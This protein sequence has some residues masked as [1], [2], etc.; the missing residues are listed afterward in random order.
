MHIPR[1]CLQRL[2][3]RTRGRAQES[4]FEAGGHTWRNITVLPAD[5]GLSSCRVRPATARGHLPGDVD[6]PGMGVTSATP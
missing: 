2:S 1:V 3:Q 6:V 4:A 5:L